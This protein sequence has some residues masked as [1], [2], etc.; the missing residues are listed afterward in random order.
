MKYNLPQEYFLFVGTIEP[1]KNL[2]YMIDAFLLS[3]KEIGHQHKLVIVGGKGWKYE[4]L[5]QY[6]KENN[7]EGDIIFPGYVAD[8]DL[9]GVY[10]GAT[11][12]LF[13]SLYEGFGI[14]LLEAMQCGLPVIATDVSCIPEVVGDAAIKVPLGDVGSFSKQ[15]GNIILDSTLH[16]SLSEKSIL[17]ASKFSWEKVASETVKVYE[18]VLSSSDK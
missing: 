1:R 15:I 10:T 8:E 12:F 14:P 2:M 11:A 13:A 17:Q 4:H 18:K 6:I 9:A 3:K 5:F 16:Q 7:L